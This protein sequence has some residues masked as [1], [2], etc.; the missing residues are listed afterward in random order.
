V[1]FEAEMLKQGM[2]PKEATQAWGKEFTRKK[3]QI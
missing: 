2:T 1:A 3:G